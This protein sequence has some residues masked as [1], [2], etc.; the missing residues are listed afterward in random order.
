MGAGI[1][2]GA[3]LPLCGQLLDGLAEDAE[4]T[5]DEQNELHGLGATDQGEV[6]DLLLGDLRERVAERTGRAVRHGLTHALLAGLPTTEAVTTNYDQLYELAVEGTGSPLDVLPTDL[7]REGVPWLLKLHGDVDRPDDIVLTRKDYLRYEARRGAL[8]G[9]VQALLATRHMLF[10]GF[11]LE[12]EH[13][14]RLIDEVRQSLGDDRS[15]RTHGTV[16]LLE[17]P[18]FFERLWPDFIVWRL[19]GEADGTRAAARRLEL[20]LD[21]LGQLTS[22]PGTHL[23]APD[24]AA[25]LEEEA[26][27]LQLS[28]ALGQILAEERTYERSAA[29]RPVRE[30]LES[31]G[32][33]PSTS[34]GGPNS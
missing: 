15:S 23:L 26:G 21:R 34:G 14:L 4:L 18:S 25:L 12:D 17:G 16:V 29:W 7:R 30:L 28:D 33:R 5:E 24:F 8:S 6:L 1:S 32:A 31:L 20:A 22:R 10:I 19:Q 11:S 9:I 13:F 2:V 27:E 3:G